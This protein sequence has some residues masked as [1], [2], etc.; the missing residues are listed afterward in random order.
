M[1]W[2]E[3]NK[4][5]EGTSIVINHTHTL[6]DTSGNKLIPGVI[7]VDG[8][9]VILFGSTVFVSSPYLQKIWGCTNGAVSQKL[10]KWKIFGS[11]VKKKKMY[12]L[13]IIEGKMRNVKK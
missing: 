10:Q 12:P 4:M 7:V 5:P 13:D 1:I 6:V 8:I 2:R 3:K 11:Y 9:D